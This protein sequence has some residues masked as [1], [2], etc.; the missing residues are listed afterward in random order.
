MKAMPKSELE[1][2]KS[3]TFSNDEQFVVEPC[4]EQDVSRAIKCDANFVRRIASENDARDR[5]MMIL[6]G[7]GPGGPTLH[8]AKILVSRVRFEYL[9]GGLERHET[10]GLNASDD[11][12]FRGRWMPRRQ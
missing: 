1:C 4:V 5:G 11:Q 3:L 7:Q 10:L 9:M 12:T 6:Y 8:N 2:S